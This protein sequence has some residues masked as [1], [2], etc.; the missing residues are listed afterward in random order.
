MALTTESVRISNNKSK[1]NG[2][3][4]L[5]EKIRTLNL[6]AI[7]LEEDKIFNLEDLDE[8][9]ISQIYVIQT[10]NPFKMQS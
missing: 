10:I 1:S 6:K 5:S 9:L 3:W 7:K 4:E 8:Y 2:Q